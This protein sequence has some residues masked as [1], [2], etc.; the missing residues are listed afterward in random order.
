MNREQNI[1]MEQMKRI[2]RTI[3]VEF[4]MKQYV[5]GLMIGPG[6]QN[7]RKQQHKCDIHLKQKKKWT[8][9]NSLEMNL[10]KLNFGI[11]R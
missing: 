9:N 3:E 2:K 8:A 6:W 4:L 5:F 1:Y 7:D 10:Y 11:S